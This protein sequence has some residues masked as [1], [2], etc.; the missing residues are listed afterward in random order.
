MNR[1]RMSMYWSMISC[2]SIHWQF[3][4]DARINILSQGQH[5]SERTSLTVQDRTKFFIVMVS[6]SVI[7]YTASNI[8][9]H[10]CSITCTANV[11]NL[12]GFLGNLV[13]YGWMCTCCWNVH[14]PFLVGAGAYAGCAYCC[15]QGEYSKVLKKMVYLEHRSFLPSIDSL[16]V[17]FPTS[18]V[19][20][21]PPL[22]KTMD[23]VCKTIASLSAPLTTRGRK[24]VI[25]SS[26][27]TGD[28][29]L[30]RFMI[31]TSTLPWNPC[32]YLRTYQNA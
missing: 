12:L 10:V 30:C 22:P 27:C 21:D 32:I 18:T 4:M 7:I 19:P 3:M 20:D 8:V 2:I 28:H 15:L 14:P 24:D 5:C 31:G 23:F 16:R 29:S 9:K 25:Q 17:N 6:T 13:W 11:K 26:G 1:T